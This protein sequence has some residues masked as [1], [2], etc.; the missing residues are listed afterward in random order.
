MRDMVKIGVILMVYAL[1]AGAALAFVNITTISR[2][3]KNKSDT[4]NAA[5]A[6]VL[7]DMAGGYELKGKDTDFPYWIGYRDEKKTE[8]GGYIF[9][10]RGCGYSSTIATMV[11]VDSN[12][13]VTGVKILFQQETPGL[14]AKVEEISH[15]ENEPWF[16][17]QF[18]GKT[19]ED[20]IKVTKDG[21]SI[22]AITG[23]TISSRA[24]ANSIYE[25]LVKLKK[26]GGGGS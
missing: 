14:G 2:I 17:R 13:A 18:K 25:G 15:G 20:D 3:T 11:G 26:T 8:P 16:T 22:D 1:F 5:R 24:V 7:P 6:E 4:E 9:I 21:G 23:A 12:G 10:A 19:V